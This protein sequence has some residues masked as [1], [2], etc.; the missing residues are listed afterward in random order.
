MD[1]VN[2]RVRDLQEYFG[3][4]IVDNLVPYK[5]MRKSVWDSESY[6]VPIVEQNSSCNW[7]TTRPKAL[8]KADSL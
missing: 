7:I 8:P 2:C 3:S 6:F 5:L 1:V 4:S